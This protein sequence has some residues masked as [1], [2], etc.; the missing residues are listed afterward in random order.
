MAIEFWT[1]EELL[2]ALGP[3]KLG[4]VNVNQTSVIGGAPEST[5]TEEVLTWPNCACRAT[6][7]SGSFQ[8]QRCSKHTNLRKP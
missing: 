4:S 2:T 1:Q 5:Y 7:R 3:G 6:G 8:L